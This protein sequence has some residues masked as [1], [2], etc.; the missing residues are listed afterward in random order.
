MI[1]F[2]FRPCSYRS[3]WITAVTKEDGSFEVSVGY[4]D[5]P[6]DEEFMSYTFETPIEINYV[7]FASKN[8]ILKNNLEWK[9]KE[10]NLT[11]TAY[12]YVYFPRCHLH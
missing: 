7:A 4:G 8:N 10:K 11:T 2:I 3:F 5:D 1:F 12:N 6:E 9:L